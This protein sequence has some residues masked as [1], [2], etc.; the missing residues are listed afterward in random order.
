MSLSLLP[1]KLC[2]ELVWQVC[3]QQVCCSCQVCVCLTAGMYSDPLKPVATG[4]WLSLAQMEGSQRC[5]KSPPPIS[6]GSLFQG[7]ENNV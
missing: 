7:L 1:L 4:R 5:T 2:E 6:F 3:I